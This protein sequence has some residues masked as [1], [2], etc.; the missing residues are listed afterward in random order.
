MS[1]FSQWNWQKQVKKQTNE[2]ISKQD[3]QAFLL[4]KR[5]WKFR[6]VAS[7]LVDVS[8]EQNYLNILKVS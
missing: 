8:D 4:V 1:F 7:K 3:V 5:F 2:Q 6:I